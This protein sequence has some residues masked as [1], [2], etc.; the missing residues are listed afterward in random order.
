MKKLLFILLLPCLVSAQVPTHIFRSTKA[1]TSAS[2]IIKPSQ[3]NDYYKARPDTCLYIYDD[4]IGGATSNGNVSRLGWSFT[5]VQGGSSGWI[6][7]IANRSGIDSIFSGIST[8]AAGGSIAFHLTPVGTIGIVHQSD[9][10]DVTFKIKLNKDNDTTIVR[11]GLADDASV[12]GTTAPGQGFYFETLTSETQWFAVMR[13]VANGEV[14]T[15]VAST[16]TNY[17][18]MRIRRIDFATDSIGYSIDG[19]TEIRIG[20]DAVEYPI[21]SVSPHMMVR[22]GDLGVNQTFSIDYF[23]LIVTN[24]AR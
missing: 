6:A 10:F 9:F 12:S 24:L 16:T 23:Q 2:G 21:S 3:W 13:S 15:A 22:N 5:A 8:T 1:D 20:V 18:T 19:G 4:F 17:V 14:R 7:G 11:I